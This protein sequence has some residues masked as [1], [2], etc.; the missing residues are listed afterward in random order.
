MSKGT[1][2]ITGASGYLGFAILLSALR[3]GYTPHIV[4]RSAAK[5]DFVKNA[6]DLVALPNA[7]TCKYFIVPD[8]TAPGSLDEATAGCD[9]VI[10]GASPLPWQLCEPELQHARL[11]VPAVACTLS[12]LES[13]RRS[14]TVKRVVC[15]SSMAAF[16][17]P[18]LMGPLI[19]DSP[20]HIS[21][22]RIPPEASPPFADVVT[23]YCASKNAALRR[24]IE[25][26][27][28]RGGAVGAGFDLV[29]LAP[30]YVAGRHPLATSTRDLWDSSNSLFLRLLAGKT[31]GW[32]EGVDAPEV[33]GGVHVDDVVE[34]HLR[35][36]DRDRVPT[37]PATGV[38][39]CTV[40]V[41]MEW[42][43]VAAAAKRLFPKEVEKGLLPCSVVG[44]KTEVRFDSG[45]VERLF[46]VKLRG[47]DEMLESLVP[48]Y[49]ELLEKEGKEG[50]G[51]PG[52][53]KD[54]K[55]GG[56]TM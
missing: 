11:V 40:A 53:M 22:D 43:D 19:P 36:L 46:G 20:V 49:L 2:L 12:A 31:A 47:L 24:S 33:A 17:P 1:L 30:V 39:L 18:E 25:W 26:M 4:V 6:P 32:T 35:A 48:Q 7:S 50:E 8:L 56:G 29:A 16:T 15:I 42:K 51:A 13:A 34:L 52:W 44:S 28:E 3:E 21:E 23:A 10:H 55:V 9:Y 38:E 41:Q 37:P 45:K 5:L 54:G 27:A 14:K